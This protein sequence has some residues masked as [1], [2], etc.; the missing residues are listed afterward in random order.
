MA[1]LDEAGCMGADCTRRA[2]LGGIELMARLEAVAKALYYP[3]ASRVVEMLGKIVKIDNSEGASL[4]DPCSGEGYAAAELARCW[5]LVAHGVELH[6]ERANTAVGLLAWARNGSY[7]QL[8]VVN[9]KGIPIDSDNYSSDPTTRPFGVL[10]LNP[11]YDEG[12]DETGANIRQEVEFLRANTKFL[13]SGG[14]LVFIPPRKILRL[15]AF[16]DFM[17]RNFY[18]VTA[19]AFPSP[20]VEDFD[21]VV[22]LA[23][24]TRYGGYS[25]VGAFDAVEALPSLETAEP[26]VLQVPVVDTRVALIGR[27][28]VVT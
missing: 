26:Y 19:Y 23:R 24:R 14:L 25:D 9:A 22:V 1:H 27:A 10:F 12:T 18:D 11:P 2:D 16:R 4:L 5:G 13:A 8:T 3:T 17:S 20:E 28:P 21:Q 6:K 7:H 15:Q